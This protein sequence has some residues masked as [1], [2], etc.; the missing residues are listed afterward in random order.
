MNIISSSLGLLDEKKLVM[1][2]VAQRK[3]EE[4][5]NRG[6]TAITYHNLLLRDVC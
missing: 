6:K 5:Q 1:T 4:R 2:N 3:Q